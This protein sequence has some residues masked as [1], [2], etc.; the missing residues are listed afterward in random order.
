M[1]Q[2]YPA[3]IRENNTDFSKQMYEQFEE[4]IQIVRKFARKPKLKFKYFYSD[5]YYI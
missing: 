3:C 5:G 1:V 4:Q 2:R